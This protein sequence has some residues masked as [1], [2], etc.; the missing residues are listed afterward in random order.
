[1]DP[2]YS[3]AQGRTSQQVVKQLG[4]LKLIH[5]D[6]AG[7]S[8]QRRGKRLAIIDDEITLD[9]FLQVQVIIIDHSQAAPPQISSAQIG[10]GEFRLIELGVAQQRLL[11]IRLVQVR[12]PQTGAGQIR[13]G[14]V[15][16]VE[17]GR[18]E[19]GA[20]QVTPT[21]VRLPQV[22]LHEDRPTQ[23]GPSQVRT[24][25]IHVHEKY[26][27]QIGS[28]QVSRGQHYVR[29]SVS[30]GSQAH[31]RLSKISLTQIGET[32]VHPREMS[33]AEIS[34]LE[35]DIIPG[36]KQVHFME[37]CATEI[38]ANRWMLCP[39]CIPRRDPLSQDIKML[40]VCHAGSFIEG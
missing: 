7:L 17:L 2:R 29:T 4:H 40:L 35:I 19:D 25:K 22:H 36:I 38:W 15:R 3:L 27:L 34:S 18:G 6:R 12:P 20:L 5:R 31:T 9:R 26:F 24:R 8:S 39:P 11:E 37:G 30:Y 16:T 10:K 32:K 14:E 23:L 21:Q 33:V 1:M 28:S 13:V